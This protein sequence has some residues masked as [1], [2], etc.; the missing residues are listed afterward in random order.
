MNGVMGKLARKWAPGVKNTP[1]NGVIYFT[2]FGPP[3]LL[4]SKMFGNL[5]MPI[6]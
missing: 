4:E 6:W 1:I 5:E 2:V 3:V